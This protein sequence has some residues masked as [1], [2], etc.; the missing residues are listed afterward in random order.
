LVVGAIAVDMRQQVLGAVGRPAHA[1][2]HLCGRL[3]RGAGDESGARR[4]RG[5]RG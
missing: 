1:V 5:G 3:S 4:R 2:G